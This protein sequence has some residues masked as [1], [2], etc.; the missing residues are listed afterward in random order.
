MKTPMMFSAVTVMA[1]LASA[2][3]AQTKTIPGE[4]KT[5]TV[6]IEAVDFQH[7]QVTAKK[8]DGTY[9]VF[10]IPAT[11]KQFE[12]LKVGDKVTARYYENIVLQVKAPGEPS[13]DKSASA[14]TR[15]EAGT[16]GTSAQQRTITAT[17]T[18]IDPNLPSITFT[19]PGDWKYTTRV[20]DK[21]ALAK[22]KVGD[23]V[24]ITWTQARVLSLEPAK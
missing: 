14:V 20:Q 13:V 18:A 10:Y 2:A 5:T 23:K 6:T 11:I 8:E 3:G 17:I 21:E 19:G 24:D 4:M 9:D 7:R 1:A 15:S 12:T 22:V 16:A